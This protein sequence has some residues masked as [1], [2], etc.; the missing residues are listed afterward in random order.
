MG[1]THMKMGDLQAKPIYEVVT[2]NTVNSNDIKYG[3]RI[4]LP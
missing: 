3:G 1:R 2:E 4:I